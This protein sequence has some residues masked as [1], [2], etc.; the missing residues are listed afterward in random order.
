MDFIDYEEKIEIRNITLSSDD[1]ISVAEDT[2]TYIRNFVKIFEEIDFDIFY[3]LG[4]RNISGFIGE[5]YKNILANYCPELCANPHPDGRPDILALD[6]PEAIRHYSDCFA[7]V[8][9]RSIPIKDML[10]PFEF[11]GLEVKCSIGSSG[12]PQTQRF[13]EDNGHSFALYEPRVGYLD[14]I[15]WWAHHSNSSNLLGLYYDYYAPFQGT[16]QILAAFYS[17]LTS[18]DWNPVSHGD[19]NNKKTSNTSLNK[20]GVTKMKSHCMF[21]ISDNDYLHQLQ[22]MGVYAEKLNQ[23]LS[24]H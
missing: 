10:T 18:D 9:G 21:S 24:K 5:I 11:G 14:G 16:P 12:K 17:E 20:Q 1:L 8:N 7:E 19:P 23:L 6:T 2:N 15:T 3:S 22:R 4:Q 13:V